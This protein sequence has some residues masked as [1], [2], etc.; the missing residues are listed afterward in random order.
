MGNP[1]KKKFL[2]KFGNR[3]PH[4]KNEE[5]KQ[6][7]F[8]DYFCAMYINT[9]SLQNCLIKTFW[10]HDKLITAVTLNLTQTKNIN[11]A[12][13]FIPAQFVFQNKKG[14]GEHSLAKNALKI[15]SQSYFKEF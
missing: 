13:V 5:S 4:N 11:H 2:L 1:N 14:R 3:N 7:E 12:R 8:L 15:Q 6:K 10:F 9:H